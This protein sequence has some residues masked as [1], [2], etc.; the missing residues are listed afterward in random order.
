MV[1]D[2]VPVE[3]SHLRK[4]DGQEQVLVLHLELA[5]NELHVFEVAQENNKK[6]Q[7]RVHREFSE[8]QGRAIKGETKADLLN[9]KVLEVDLLDVP[10][11]GQIW[12]AFLCE[13]IQGRFHLVGRLRATALVEIASQRS[14]VKLAIK[15]HLLLCA[16][17][18]TLLGLEGMFGGQVQHVDG[19]LVSLIA[20]VSVDVELKWLNLKAEVL[21]VQQVLDGLILDKQELQVQK[22]HGSLVRLPPKDNSVH[23]PR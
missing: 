11:C 9:L 22:V 23:R 14:G 8:H 4:E 5:K 21:E 3:A 12:L 15:S 17:N 16:D 13:L 1:G 20:E 2:L 7:S 19:V 18:F 10:A 6:L